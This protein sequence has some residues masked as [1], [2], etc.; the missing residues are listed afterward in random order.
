MAKEP[1]KGKGMGKG[2]VRSVAD[3]LDYKQKD[4][5]TTWLAN[6]RALAGTRTMELMTAGQLEKQA[7]DFL[8]VIT[9]AF[10]SEVYDDMEHPSMRPSVQMLKEISASRAQQ[11][12]TAS[13]TATF[14]FSLQDAIMEYLQVEIGDNPELLN[15]E[16]IK[17]SKIIVK[18]GLLTFETFAV[19]RDDVIGQQTRSIMELSTP[20]LRVW[21]EVLLLPLIGTFDTPR[22]QQMMETVL[23][24]IVDTESRVL[25]LDVTGVPVMLDVTGVPV[26]DTKTASHLLKT[27]EACR[28]L[29]CEVIMTGISPTT[30][31]TMT[32]LDIELAIVKTVGTLRAGMVEAYKVIGK[33]VVARS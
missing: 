7:A 24:V 10:R 9:D 26:M 2:Q 29:G 1:G 11:G 4:I 20:A 5:M 19:T 33:E 13:E 23:Q 32:K 8:R 18:M 6:I 28:M 31:Q 14:I 3:L 16:L 27:V 25:L 17:M 12:F 22:A 30:A 15:Q 21:D